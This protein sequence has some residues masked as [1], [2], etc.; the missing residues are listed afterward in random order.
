MRAGFVLCGYRCSIPADSATVKYTTSII[1][2]TLAL[3]ESAG[4][5]L[6]TTLLVPAYHLEP[7]G[8]DTGTGTTSL[9]ATTNSWDADRELQLLDTI[10]TGTVVVRCKVTIPVDE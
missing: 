10:V 8:A 7:T 1:Y 3:S 9:T 6:C 5:S 4:T 2:F